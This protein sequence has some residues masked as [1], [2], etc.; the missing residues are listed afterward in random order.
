MAHAVS[1]PVTRPISKQVAGPL[2]RATGSGA[3][4]AFNYIAQDGAQN[5][6]SAII[7]GFNAI[8]NAATNKTFF[9]YQATS[10]D[11]YVGAYNHTSQAWEGPYFYVKGSLANDAH[12]TPYMYVE[13]DGTIHIIGNAH[14]SQP[15]YARSS[16]AGDASSVAV[17]TAPNASCTYATIKQ[18]S[19]GKL[20]LFRRTGDHLSP[21]AYQTS[22]DHGATW[23]ADTNFLLFG[24]AL[25]DTAYAYIIKEPT[26]DEFHI[27][28][29]WQDENN[30]VSNPFSSSTIVNRY[31]VYYF[32]LTAAGVATNIAGTVLGTY[33]PTLASSNSETRIL[34]T[35][36][37]FNFCN[38]PM[39][40]TDANKAPIFLINVG[41]TPSTGI[42][43]AYKVL[44]WNGSSLSQS[45]ITTTDY[46]LD[47]YNHELV[48]GTVA[49]NNAVVRAYLTTGGSPG[50]NGDYDIVQ[51]DRGG[52]I[53]EWT[54]AAGLGSW[55]QT[56]T[57]QNAVDTTHMVNTPC[58]VQNYANSA[59]K[60]F[61]NDWQ[62]SMNGPYNA[63]VYAWGTGGNVLVPYEAETKTLLN[64]FSVTPSTADQFDINSMI[65][66]LKTSGIYA[67]LDSLWLMGGVDAQSSRL[68]WV[69]SNNLIANGNSG[70]GPAF[71]AYAGFTGNGT[72]SYHDT[73]VIPSA[74]TKFVQNDA[75]MGLWT[76]T[77]SGSTAA[78]A[79]QAFGT[80]DVYI[81]AADSVS[82]NLQGKINAT[83]LSQVAVATAQYL[84]IIQ[85]TG[86]SLGQFYRNG[87]QLGANLTAVSVAKDSNAAHKLWVGAVN[88]GT[89]QY[90]SRQIGAFFLGGSLTVVQ[91]RVLYN[92]LYGWFR[93]KGA[94]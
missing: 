2:G 44:W 36:T 18:T 35:V 73:G 7:G 46:T 56:A 53:T 93:R 32:K 85:R 94:L 77:S 61:Y 63:K 49:G 33:P 92:A 31:N 59:V 82:G 26:A 15:T 67:L 84:S 40:V 28:Y 80:S 66:S 14:H 22:T 50:T 39:V 57:V 25:N 5:A 64:K 75:C 13:T 9:C 6:V 91:Q 1:F 17:Q 69:G 45:T 74:L 62:I 42:G 90:S 27:A 23:S 71:V 54:S 41:T 52:N 81:R 3:Y 51:R 47:E 24:Q 29:T 12:G 89:P 16:I 58:L 37:A 65:R 38:V 88:T 43:H 55:S 4:P 10:Y 20:W 79:G 83:A 21:W 70:N 8:Y 11:Q 30:S 78:D 72:N 34:D 48:S 68:D 87:A 60:L 76:F 19:D 86:A